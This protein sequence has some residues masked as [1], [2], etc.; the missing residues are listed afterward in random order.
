M[1][2]QADVMEFAKTCKLKRKTIMESPIVYG[3]VIAG[4][5]KI[6]KY[7]IWRVFVALRDR[8]TGELL[9]LRTAY[10]KRAALPENAY[11]VYWTESG[12]E[13]GKIKVAPETPVYIGLN[14]G[15]ANET[16]ALTQAILEARSAFNLK[17]RKGGAVNKA[18]LRDPRNQYSIENLLAE[19]GAKSWRVYPMALHDVSDTTATGTSNWRHMTFPGYIQPKYDGTRFMIVGHPQ[20]TVANGSLMDKIDGYSRGLESYEGHDHILTAMQPVVAKYPGWYFDGELWKSGY[21]LQHISG[22]SR[23]LE[24]STRPEALKL[25]YYIFDMFKLDEPLPWNERMAKLLSVR[26]EFFSGS[27]EPEKTIVFAPTYEY[28]S[29]ETAEA[30]Y[31][32]FLDSGY[33]GGVL[34]NAD[35]PYEFGVTKEV[36]SYKTMK[37]KPMPDDE[38]PV[39]GFTEGGR[40]KDIGALKWILETNAETLAGHNAKYGLSAKLKPVADD[41][42]FDA[43]PKGMTYDER[44]AAFKYL[45]DNPKYFDQNLKGQLMRVQYSIISDFGKPQQ[46]K[47]LGFHDLALNK[48]FIAD[49]SRLLE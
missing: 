44:R 21:G 13:D 12:R 10:I 49:Y 24:G 28:S 20:I 3:S 40:G 31:Q 6:L 45:S 26:E 43:V 29:R 48:K 38:W 18:D 4:K 47:V 32:E 7:T 2:N 15:N 8:E 41:N 19:G 22:S 11:A 46:P 14:A 17:I 37:L 27:T 25:D 36:R 23:R 9:E 30:K 1:S 35:S 39:I 34:R 42:R 5:A 33:E 16:T